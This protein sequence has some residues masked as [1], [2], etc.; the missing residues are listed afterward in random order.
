ME[1][2]D[3][4]MGRRE[5]AAAS[6]TSEILVNGE[7]E[8][9]PAGCTV[10][11]LIQRLDLA[12]KRVAVAINR[13]VVPRSSYAHVSVAAGDQIEILEAVGGG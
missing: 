11:Q 1:R 4:T 7:R 10:L 5:D 9:V 6:T 3:A 12:G 2:Y 8:S 13:S